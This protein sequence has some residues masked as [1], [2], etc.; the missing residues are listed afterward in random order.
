MLRPRHLLPLLFLAT[1]LA[2]L[3]TP[4]SAQAIYPTGLPQWD[5]TNKVLF[6]GHGTPL[7][8]VRSY[9]DETQRGDDIDIFEDFAGIQD[10]YV[11]SMTAGPDG[12]ALLAA[13]LNFGG[14]NIRKLILTYS[15]SGE[16]L[17]TWD[18]A[19]QYA[20]VIAYSQDDDAIFVL[21]ERET[22]GGHTPPDSPVLVEYSRDGRVLKTM[23]P[24]STLK[25]R[26]DSFLAGGETGEPALR[27]T[28]DRIFFYAPSNREAVMCDRNG[29]VLAQR[30]VTEIVNRIAA[31]DGLHLVQI[32]QVDF[33]D[34]GDIVLELLLSHGSDLAL[35]VARINIKSSE[36]T[37]VH[38]TYPGP[39]MAF[40]GVKDNQYLYL[41]YGHN[42]FIQSP[43][44]PDPLPL[45]AKRT[46]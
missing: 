13:I 37:I 2:I 42:L 14:H 8:P 45:S 10:S 28:K 36:S 12:T 34:N 19:P 9:L 31:D 21:G 6:F 5:S 39:P 30:S 16:L 1:G 22:P 33:N 7:A 4:A 17:K 40:V 18:P 38:R 25:D 24:A 29:V 46:D 20:R 26:G 35:E 15:P 32:H 44:S 41:A 11:D 27:V 43:E 23:I 3:N